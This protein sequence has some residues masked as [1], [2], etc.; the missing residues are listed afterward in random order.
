MIHLITHLANTM[1]TIQR[2]TMLH[3]LDIRWLPNGKRRIF[4]IKFVAKDGRLIFFP[5]AHACGAG[6][7]DNKKYRL[8]GIQ[9]CDADGN[10]DGHVYPVRIDNII[11]YNSMRVV[12]T[13]K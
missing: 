8:R 7:M 13:Q 10:P 6:K 2:N 5:K 1:Q 3:D 4:S 9:P 11:Q 12:F